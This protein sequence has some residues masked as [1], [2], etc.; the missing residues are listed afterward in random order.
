MDTPPLGQ[1]ELAYTVR[2]EVPLEPGTTMV[3]TDVT[4]ETPPA[5]QDV[6]PPILLVT[7]LAQLVIGATGL[8]EALATEVTVT[9][10]VAVTLS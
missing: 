2:V 6:E 5:G 8:Q 4:V 7:V 9:Y 1:V 10:P 3:L